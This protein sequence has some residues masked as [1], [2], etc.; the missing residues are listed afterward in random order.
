MAVVAVVRAVAVVA[1]VVAKLVVEKRVVAVHQELLDPV[2]LMGGVQGVM[3]ISGPIRASRA[4]P[5]LQC[6]GGSRPHRLHLLARTPLL[7]VVQLA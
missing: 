2:R 1:G 3:M 5:L 7:L 6:R 4:P